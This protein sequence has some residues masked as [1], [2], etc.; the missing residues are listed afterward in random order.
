MLCILT[1]STGSQEGRRCWLRNDQSVR[2]GRSYSID[3]SLPQDTLL[4]REHFAVEGYTDGFRI[5]DLGSSNGTFLNGKPVDLNEIGNGDTILAGNTKFTVQFETTNELRH[6]APEST[7]KTINPDPQD[8]GGSEIRETEYSPIDMDEDSW[9]M[10]LPNE[11]TVV[12]NN[13]P[14]ATPAAPTEVPMITDSPIA[15]PVP[16][17][18]PISE[19]P[20]RESPLSESPLRE[21]PTNK[22]AVP[23]L[24]TQ[25]LGAKRLDTADASPP[26]PQLPA[27]NAA[28]MSACN[29]QLHY[30]DMLFRI[31]QN[32]LHLVLNTANLDPPTRQIVE[33]IFSTT[34]IH[35]GKNVYL[36]RPIESVDMMEAIRRCWGFD[37]LFVLVVSGSVEALATSL[38]ASVD[39]FESTSLFTQK[40][41]NSMPDVNQMMQGVERLLCEHD[42]GQGWTL[43]ARN[44]SELMSS[45]SVATGNTDITY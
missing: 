33:N 34:L 42:R 9:A 19:S 31:G 21:S 23:T 43:V 26:A 1:I 10:N 18:A 45:A 28:F 11:P 8:D 2:F 20:L 16:T 15:S 7:K 30:E 36:V 44:Y 32:G 14:H 22:P 4:S 13:K 40:M 29:D 39:C 27:V 41:V 6:D 17:P 25:T 24:P 3:Y 37:A 38:Q 5:R 35:L 12:V